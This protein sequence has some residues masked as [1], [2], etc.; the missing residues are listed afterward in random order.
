MFRHYRKLINHLYLSSDKIFTTRIAN[1]KKKKHSSYSD[2]QNS[3]QPEKKIVFTV[4]MP[5][6]TFEISVKWFIS[7]APLRG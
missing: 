4:C 7:P 5:E 1:Q 6:I 3:E 2:R